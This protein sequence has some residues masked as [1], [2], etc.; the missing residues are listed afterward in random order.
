MYIKLATYFE[1][2]DPR[3]GTAISWLLENQLADGGW[4]CDTLRTGDQHSSFHTT[5]STLEAFA[6]VRRLGE[7]GA[8][9]EA[10]EAGREFFLKHHLFRS[11][12]TGKVALPA[13][14]KLSF[15]PRWHFDVL[16]GLDHVESESA[17]WDP[18]LNDAVSLLISKRSNNGRWPVQNRHQGKRWFEMERTGGPSR[19]NTLRA[20]RVLAWVDTSQDEAPT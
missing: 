3:V 1:Y 17:T 18:R 13:F 2:S 6:Q 10:L 12:K 7:D 11:H 5:I 19:W 9:D 16:R 8:I 20:L 14:T 15:P 4:N